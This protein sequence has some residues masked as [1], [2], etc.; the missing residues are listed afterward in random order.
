[1]TNSAPPPLPLLKPRRLT[2]G[3]TIGLAAPA[4]PPRDPDGVRLAGELI[5]TLGFRV[6]PAAHVFDR[7]GYFA[8]A[9]AARAADLNQ[10]FADPDVDAIFCVRGGYGASRLLPALDY[11]LVRANPKVL[12]GYSD[13]TALLLGLY[14]RTGLVTFHGPIAGQDLSPY[15]LAELQQVLYTPRAP[16]PLAAPPPFAGGPGRVERVNRVR[17]LVPGRAR[18]RLLGG[19]LSLVAHL[20][21]TPYLP[22]LAGAILFLEDVSEAIYSID[23]MLTQ[24]WLAG[25]LEQVAGLVF[26]KFTEPPASTWPQD[27][28]L[29][30]VLAERAQALGIP[31]VMGLLIGHVPDQATLPVGCLAEL[32]AEAGTLTLLEEAVL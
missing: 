11:D 22:D 26:G 7:A 3:Q 18:G 27:R 19:N 10:L 9:D 20:A 32:D 5:E 23:R 15:T 25:I 12:L 2:P 14:Q 29:E 6:K 4:S 28:G 24:L 1:M 13:I 31:A 16:L 8:G 21:G 30:E 17:A